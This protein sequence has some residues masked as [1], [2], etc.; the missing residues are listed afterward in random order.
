[1]M[2]RTLALAAAAAFAPLALAQTPCTMQEIGTLQAGPP[3][4]NF[5]QAPVPLGFNFLFN[6]TTYDEIFISDHGI[7][8]LATGG[9]PVPI[10]GAAVYTPG[11]ANLDALGA[12]CI[13]A[14]W[15]DHSTQG[16][17][18]PTSANAGIWVDNTSGSHCTVTWIDNEPYLS[19]AAGAFSC[20]VTLFDTGEIR[21]RMDSRCNNTSSTYGA[22]ETVIGVH[23]L[24]N[25]VPASSDFSAPA[26]TVTDPTCYEEFIGSGP[27]G[28][29]TP[30]PNFDLADTTLTFTPISPGWLVIN[31]PL[32]CG[33]VTDV[34]TGCGISLA[35]TT[36]PLV[37]TQWGVEVSGVATPAPFPVFLVLG[38]ATPPTPAGVLFP[39]LFGP[40]CEAYM[41]GALGLV[42]I[43]APAG[44]VASQSLTVPFNPNLSG[45]TLTA[46]GLSFNLT[47]PTFSLSNANE[48]TIGY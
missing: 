26:T 46:Q 5:T 1:M 14:Y 21:I 43:G 3:I 17:G 30:D 20:S 19:Y 35:T 24:N 25:A 9:I 8:T 31:T 44:G 4:D 2:N 41:D 22:V 23:T 7:I 45:A 48:V 15:G 18:T 42:N 28:S 38:N 33:S 36:P 13:F 6:G 16:F 37:G 10:G 40:T 11:S 29:N 12:D 32:E 39:T 47:G 34:G 27:A